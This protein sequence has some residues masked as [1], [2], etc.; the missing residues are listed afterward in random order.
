[1]HWRSPAL[2]VGNFD[3]CGRTGTHVFTRPLPRARAPWYGSDCDAVSDNL[4]LEPREAVVELEVEGAR[5][6]HLAAPAHTK[7]PS[8]WRGPGV[9]YDHHLAIGGRPVVVVAVVVVV[10]FPFIR[11][12][13]ALDAQLVEIT[14]HSSTYIVVASIV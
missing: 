11:I 14:V 12:D 4:R 10:D 6:V 7:W 9:R 8:R 2:R 3:R 5:D 13:T 1:M